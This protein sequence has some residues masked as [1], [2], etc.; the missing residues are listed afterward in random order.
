MEQPEGGTVSEIVR[1]FTDP[2][3]Q[4]LKLQ[5][6]TNPAIRNR[7]EKTYASMGDREK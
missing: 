5:H 7:R 6:V 3:Y 2:A 4:K 1:V